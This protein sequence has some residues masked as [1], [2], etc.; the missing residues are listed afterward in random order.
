MSRFR[1]VQIILLIIYIGMLVFFTYECFQT[2]TN[3]SKQA[4]GVAQVVANVQEAI[5]RKPVV[6]DSNY[7]TL[8]S[9]LIGHYGYFCILGL[10]SILFYMTLTGFKAYIRFIIHLAAGIVF[11]FLSEFLAEAITEGRTA[12][13]AD[14][15][16]D[17]LGLITLSGIFIMIYYI[18][19][20]HKKKKEENGE[21]VGF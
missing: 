19:V 13:I 21:K 6:V 11:A 12:S 3:A 15:G 9:K 20:I 14:V 1:V 7:K 5:T 18:V 2:G 17:I 16:I 4:S 10:V 8:I